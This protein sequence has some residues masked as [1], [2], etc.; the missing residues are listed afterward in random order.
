L[1]A[2]SH[3]WLQ[4][5]SN[6]EADPLDKMSAEDLLEHALDDMA[7]DIF[8]VPNPYHCQ[9]NFMHNGLLLF[10]SGSV[11]DFGNRLMEPNNYLPYFPA[12][13]SDN[14]KLIKPRKFVSD[15]V[16]DIL[17]RAKPTKWQIT[18]LESNL[19][20]QDMSLDDILDD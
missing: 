15:E 10:L 1:F 17:D 18:M 19:D 11:G 13:N 8:K 9:K 2:T 3:T 14:H 5:Q 20:V 16:N 6:A 7:H 12:E 4:Q